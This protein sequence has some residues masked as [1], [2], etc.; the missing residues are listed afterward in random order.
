M[1]KSNYK[2]KNDVIQMTGTFGKK[3]HQRA[4]TRYMR[5]SYN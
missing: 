5:L 1:R 2:E 4:K 3:C